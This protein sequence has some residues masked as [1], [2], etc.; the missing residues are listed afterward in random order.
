MLRLIYNVLALTS[1]VSAAVVTTG[2]TGGT[3]NRKEIRELAKSKDE[4][5]IYLQAL[6]SFQAVPQ[7][8]ETSFYGIMGK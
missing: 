5:D 4:L 6:A 3:Q 7:S 1:A 2:A 8:N